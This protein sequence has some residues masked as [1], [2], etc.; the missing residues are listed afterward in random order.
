LTIV[1]VVGVMRGWRSPL[2]GVAAA[3]VVLAALVAALGPRPRA[4][5][6]STHCG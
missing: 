2:I 3:A 5:S 1:L 4:C 6:R